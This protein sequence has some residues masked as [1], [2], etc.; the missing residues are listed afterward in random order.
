ML[1]D[2]NLCITY[3]FCMWKDR[4]AIAQQQ[5][6]NRKKSA[7]EKYVQNI[8]VDNYASAEV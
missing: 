6:K 1:H 7:A 5:K 2:T 4:C 8:I 3:F